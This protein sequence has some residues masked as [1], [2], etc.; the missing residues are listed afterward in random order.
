MKK[1]AATAIVLAAIC[2]VTVIFAAGNSVFEP[3]TPT[4][5]WGWYWPLELEEPVYIKD[6]TTYVALRDFCS[7]TG[8]QVEWDEEKQTIQLNPYYYQVPVYDKYK[9]WGTEKEEGVIPDEETAMKIG[10]IIL[11]TYLGRELEYETEDKVYFLECM[12]FPKENAW[13][14]YQTCRYKDGRPL[15][16]GDG[17][18]ISVTLNKMNG[19]V[20]FLSIDSS[21]EE[22]E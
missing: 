7:A 2:S 17:Q 13:S 9:T 19:H 3:F 20:Q 4:I 6:G 5:M 8:T 11:E 21:A 1:H 15:G 10:K 22:L 14:V 12:Y 16:I 18:S